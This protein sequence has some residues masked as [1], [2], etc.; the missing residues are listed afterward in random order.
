MSSQGE[1]EGGCHLR[2]T[3]R[4]DC[5]KIV[6]GHSIRMPISGT[7]VVLYK[8]IVVVQPSSC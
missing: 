1:E 3:R 2:G 8:K 6:P 4:K 7:V 5:R